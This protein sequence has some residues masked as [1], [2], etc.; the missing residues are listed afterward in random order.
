MFSRDVLYIRYMVGIRHILLST[1]IMNAKVNE[2][3]CLDEA[4]NKYSLLPGIG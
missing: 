2:F 4:W 3:V 1:N